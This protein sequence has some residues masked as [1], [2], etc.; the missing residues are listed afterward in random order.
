MENLRPGETCKL[1]AEVLGIGLDGKPRATV[2]IPKGAIVSIVS[3]PLDG[4]RLVDV[5]WN[6]KVLMVFAQDLRDRAMRVIGRDF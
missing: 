4:A 1:Q 2:M 6:G 3:E 5:A